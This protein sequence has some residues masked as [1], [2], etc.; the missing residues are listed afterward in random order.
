MSPE[1]GSAEFSLLSLAGALLRRGAG[2]PHSPQLQSGG[3]LVL[4]PL[5]HSVWRHE[6][7]HEQAALRLELAVEVLGGRRARVEMSRAAPSWAAQSATF[8]LRSS[9]MGSRSGREIGEFEVK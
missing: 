6:A 2:G 9:E 3:A 7:P 1:T 8:T 5:R 4:E